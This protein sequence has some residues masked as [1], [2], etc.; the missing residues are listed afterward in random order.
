MV[1]LC[2]FIM[3]INMIIIIITTNFVFILIT[4]YWELA[5]RLKVPSQ[6]KP[7]HTLTVLI[8][9]LRLESI[10]NIYE[11][12]LERTKDIC[13]IYLENTKSYA[14][15]IWTMHKM[16]QNHIG[17]CGKKYMQN[18]NHIETSGK[19]M[20]ICAKTSVVHGDLKHHKGAKLNNVDWFYHINQVDSSSIQSLNQILIYSSGCC[21]C[22]N[23]NFCWCCCFQNFQRLAGCQTLQNINLSLPFFLIFFDIFRM[24]RGWHR[25]PNTTK[26][27]S[28]FTF[29]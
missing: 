5:I 20:E 9:P 29:F 28:F 11:I 25:L 12:Y 15:Y 1:L 26:Y 4:L 19:Y 21:L 16:N 23:L 17:K 13:E 22:G 6:S 8:N 2:M 10:E 14:K 27:R 24:F 18:W 3:A 7:T